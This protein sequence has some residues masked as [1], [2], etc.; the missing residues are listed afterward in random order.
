MTDLETVLAA[1]VIVIACC[2]GIFALYHFWQAARYEWTKESIMNRIKLI[3]G[4]G[5]GTWLLG[6]LIPSSYF[7]A[8]CALLTLA[9]L[10]SVRQEG[11]TGLDASGDSFKQLLNVK[12]SKQRSP[13]KT[14]K[15]AQKLGESLHALTVAMEKDAKKADR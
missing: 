12:V 7:W 13:T 10:H 3:I 6:S 4:V 5:F 8:F 14:G 11:H 15:Q 9:A 2:F 1:V